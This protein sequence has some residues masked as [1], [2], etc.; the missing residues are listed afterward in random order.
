MKI[1]EIQT[2]LSKSEKTKYSIR[3]ALYLIFSYCSSLEFNGHIFTIVLYSWLVTMQIMNE[4]GC[5]LHCDSFRGL[6]VPID[7]ILRKRTLSLSPWESNPTTS[8]LEYEW[9]R[10]YTALL[11]HLPT[12]IYLQN[13]TKYCI[14]HL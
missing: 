3:P 1:S 13:K 14:F 2:R 8:P 7:L 6:L 9:V 12:V 5:I 4:F 11:T 10:L